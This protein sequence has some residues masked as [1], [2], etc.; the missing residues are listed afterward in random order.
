MLSIG[1]IAKRRSSSDSGSSE[2]EVAEL[3]TRILKL[4]K[5]QQ[6]LQKANEQLKSRLAANHAGAQKP[7][8]EILKVFRSAH[9]SCR[10]F[11]KDLQ[12]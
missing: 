5:E 3:E 10:A 12:A 11:G 8:A 6:E 9:S 4:L 7:R 1:L 2:D